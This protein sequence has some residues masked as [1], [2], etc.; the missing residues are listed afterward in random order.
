MKE[1]PILKE[2]KEDPPVG[3]AKIYNFVPP[4]AAANI[5]VKIPLSSG[6][7]KIFDDLDDGIDFEKI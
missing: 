3:K 7:I 4:S 5:F 6:T 1:T 2:L